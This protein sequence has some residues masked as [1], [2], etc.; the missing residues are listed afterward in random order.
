M[1]GPAAL[2]I[3]GDAYL[4]DTQHLTLEE[5]GAY[6]K[7][8]LIAWRSPDCA[9]PNDDRRIALMLGIGSK[10]WTALRP[11]VMAFWAASE[12][13]WQQKRLLKEY[14]R[15]REMVRLKRE[16]AEA[17]W[18]DKSLKDNEGVDADAYANGYAPQPQP[19]PL[20]PS[21]IK[22]DVVVGADADEREP[23]VDETDEAINGKIDLN[24]FAANCAEAGGVNLISPGHIVIAVDL[25]KAWLALGAD[26]AFILKNIQEG[27]AAAAEPISSL[28]YF[29]RRIRTAT[30]RRKALE[31]GQPPAPRNAKPPK[32]VDPL[33]QGAL[34]RM[35]ARRAADQAGG[36]EL[37]GRAE[38]WLLHE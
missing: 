19:Q 20:T 5:H 3:F 17:R 2:P 13:G 27:V 10:K 36:V 21:G 6:F 37:P 33:T 8:M 30:A 25:V 15:V 35:A 24:Q 7:L 18:G 23:F 32:A 9:L 38:Q 4:A 16:A 12:S 31:N 34:D 14:L 26:R 28:R 29:D 1:R 22:D 11:S